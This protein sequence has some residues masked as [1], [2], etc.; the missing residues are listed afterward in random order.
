MINRV[1]EGQIKNI[2]HTHI[3]YVVDMF[4][5]MNLVA[6]II[7][8]HLKWLGRITLNGRGQ[9][10]IWPRLENL[11]L[12][13]WYGSILTG[14]LTVMLGGIGA[15]GEGDDRWWDGWMAS[16]ARWTWVW[17]N[18]GTLWW[19]GR[20]GV[21]QFMG[22]QRVRHDWATEL[23]WTELYVYLIHLNTLKR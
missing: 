8:R 7:A 17:V 5:L 6:V 12:Y 19:T 1:T 23:K 2:K 9:L 11:S 3:F 4:Y 13:F 20:P 16:P 14:T 10:L 18:S 21:L 15:G 22:S